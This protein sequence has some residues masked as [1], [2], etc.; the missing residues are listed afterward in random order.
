M[1][2]RVNLKFMTTYWRVKIEATTDR[3]ALFYGWIPHK[4]EVERDSGT[5]TGETRLHHTAYIKP[6]HEH[7]SLG[8]M[9]KPL[10]NG[11]RLSLR[12]Y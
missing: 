2:Y 11:I 5:P 10:R 1:N 9:N 3:F 4:T 8:V 6:E 7:I 12:K